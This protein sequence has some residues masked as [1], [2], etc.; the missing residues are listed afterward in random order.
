M[1]KNE[2]LVYDRISQDPVDLESAINI[3]CDVVNK[4]ARTDLVLKLGEML[5]KVSAYRLTKDSIVLESVIVDIASIIK[6]ISDSEVADSF[7]HQ[8]IDI[9]ES[10]TEKSSDLIHFTAI[11]D[12]WLDRKVLLDGYFKFLVEQQIVTSQ[13]VARCYK[14]YINSYLDE[15]GCVNNAGMVKLCELKVNLQSFVAS[16][17]QG[18]ENEQKRTRNIKSAAKKMIMFLG[19]I[20][21]K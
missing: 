2:F 10:V 20:L 12:G 19:N 7:N 4:T 14:S 16:K 5:G 8:K 17:V 18:Y 11:N 13:A 15:S 3:I 21:G 1:N 9:Y 6:S